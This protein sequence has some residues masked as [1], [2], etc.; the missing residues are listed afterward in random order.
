MVLPVL[1]PV[2]VPAPALAPTRPNQPVSHPPTP[3][4]ELALALAVAVVSTALSRPSPQRLPG[5]THP[6][7][8]TPRHTAASPARH[9]LAPG[10]E[11]EPGLVLVLDLELEL[12]VA[13]SA[14]ATT[15]RRRLPA[16]CLTSPPLLLL[17][18]PCLVTG[19]ILPRLFRPRRRRRLRP[20]L[21]Q[22]LLLCA[23]LRMLIRL[24]GGSRITRLLSSGMFVPLW[25]DLVRFRLELGVMVCLDW[26]AWGPW[27]MNGRIGKSW[28]VLD[29]EEHI[30]CL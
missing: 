15:V 26:R 2:P 17:R 20:R 29:M 14:I 21:A 8:P 16:P 3:S 25:V 12:A 4:L 5:A 24:G 27:I 22:C 10:L 18:P 1:V 30:E 6:T 7:H 9:P 23:T 19:S 28:F 11:P 13:A